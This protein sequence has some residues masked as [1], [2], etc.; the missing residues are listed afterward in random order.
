M[1]GC[2]SPTEGSCPNEGSTIVHEKEREVSMW[3]K[4][5]NRRLAE[6]KTMATKVVQKE[7]YMYI[8]KD[9][10]DRALYKRHRDLPEDQSAVF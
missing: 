2:D 1:T 10:W 6:D 7:Y 5:L 8:G 3:L 4:K 9:T